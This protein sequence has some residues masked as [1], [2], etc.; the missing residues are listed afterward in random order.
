L[1]YQSKYN[2]TP[3]NTYT[4]I[5]EKMS[6]GHGTNDDSNDGSFASSRATF[7]GNGYSGLRTPS[8]DNTTYILM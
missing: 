3:V 6:V 1:R 8:Y 7:T 2:P 5:G 4:S